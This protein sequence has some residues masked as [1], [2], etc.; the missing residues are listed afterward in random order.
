MSERK[1]IG[2]GIEDYKEIVDKDYYY[3][4]KTLLIKELRDKG[5]KVNLFTRPR[6]FGKTL[7]L[8]MLR[9]FFEADTDV[10]GNVID[11]SRYFAGMKIMETAETY[12]QL[13]GQFPVINLSLKSAKQP[14]YEMSYACLVDEI[15]KEYER[16]R[17][18]L[19]S[20]ALID[21]NKEK[22]LQIMNRRA[23][24]NEYATALKFLSECLK[25]YH[26][27][28]TIILIDEYDVPLENAWFE[29]FYGQMIKFIRSVFESSLKTN[30]NLEFAVVTGCLR[31][32]KESIFT[33]LNNLKV[34]SVLSN[35][36]AECYGFVQSEVE[37]MLA[38]L[39]CRGENAGS[40]AV[41]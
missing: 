35:N 7:A 33:G 20:D 25:Q 2:I 5:G 36:F 21:V 14:R 12:T 34:I 19:L 24:D 22:Y 17:Y 30:N 10:K 15:C 9:T 37:T 8:S 18:V 4:D 6:R 16:H 28:N 13:Q 41:V 26:G 1:R 29:G 3:V 39:W 32:S 27:R 38:I 23:A 31:I 40:K 11:N